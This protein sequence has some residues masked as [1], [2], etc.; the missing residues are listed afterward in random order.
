VGA[1]A[2][3]S[4]DDSDDGRF[5]VAASFYPL[6][7][8]ARQVGGDAIDI[9]DLTPAGAEPHDLEPTTDQIDAIQSADVVLLMGRHFQPSMEVAARRKSDGLVITMLD[10][11][12]LPKGNDDPHVWLDPVEMQHIVS[13][14]REA[15][16]LQDSAH[17]RDFLRAE[18]RYLDELR[19]LDA[20]YRN[21]LMTCRSRIIV[22]AHAA[23]GW[24]AKRYGLEQHAI[25]GISPDREPD[26]RRI[27]D[28]AG[29]VRSQKVTTVFTEELVSPKIANTLARE[30]GVKTAVLD[31]IESIAKHK[32]RKGAD[33]VSIMREN[34][35]TLRRALGCT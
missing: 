15:L 35:E 6:A 24:L 29:L 28:L 8:A 3:C 1:A 32:Q 5:G 13:S 19:A 20:D 31:P 22:T 27:A 25:A 12:R 17:E 4:S 7:E 23:F 21:A 30:A 26:P 10:A 33:Y 34:L 18:A 16:Q 14:V 9:T 11:L 2:G